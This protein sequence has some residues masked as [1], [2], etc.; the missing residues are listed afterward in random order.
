MNKP[1]RQALMNA[2]VHR[3]HK[4]DMTPTSMFPYILGERNGRHILNRDMS[5]KSWSAVLDYRHTLTNSPHSVLIVATRHD[6]SRMCKGIF[7]DHP[8]ATVITTQWMNGLLT[9]FTTV[10]N[11]ALKFRVTPNNE[12]TPSMRKRFNLHI[13]PLEKMLIQGE[14]PQLIIFFNPNDHRTAIHEAR[15][16][17]VMTMGITN[18]DCS[19][20][21]ELDYVVPGNDV[22]L[23]PMFMYM[24]LI[25]NARDSKSVQTNT[26]KNTHP[27]SSNR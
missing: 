1:S 16:A 24:M 4:I 27:T 23:E 21:N 26:Q 19:F 6:V 11:R 20:A 5:M 10:R 3:G 2:G 13:L 18:S 25:H 15:L 14:L 8:I 7:R 12:L 17:G 22:L 9:N